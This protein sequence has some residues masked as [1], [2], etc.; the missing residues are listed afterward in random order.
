MFLGK[1]SLLEWNLHVDG[2]DFPATLH[3]R[4]SLL[5]VCLRGQCCGV[6]AFVTLVTA[7]GARVCAGGE[8]V[9]I[10]W[11]ALFAC[12]VDAQKH[13]SL[14]L[15]RFALCSQPTVVVT[16]RKGPG[17]TGG[18]AA[19]AWLYVPGTRLVT[20]RNFLTPLNKVSI[21]VK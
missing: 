19:S 16:P 21:Y 2:N 18:A 13:L 1:V 11:Y 14:H 7:D 12:P 8:W 6:L 17:G 15:G 3:S 20:R 5:S 9:Y 10:F 4:S